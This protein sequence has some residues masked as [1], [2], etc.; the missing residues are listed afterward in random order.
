M[1]N[2][3]TITLLI[4]ALIAATAVSSSSVA[5]AQEA[6]KIAVVSLS[7]VFDNYEK[8]R[9]VDATLEKKGE[10]KNK[11]RDA[12][13]EKVNKLKDEVQLLSRQ[14][15]RE[16]EDKL[17]ALMR[18]LQ[19]FDRDAR[20]ELRRERD[21]LVKEIFEEMD[22]IISRYGKEHGYDLIF[23]ERV[24]IYADDT[25]DITKDITGLLNKKR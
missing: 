10:E 20:I 25:V 16:K 21:D 1:M 12:L 3:R 17:N 23:D 5:F 18:E 8:T 15:R 13:V 22:E 6:R 4:V 14:A 24:L 9:D 2:N 11:E 7:R 19:D